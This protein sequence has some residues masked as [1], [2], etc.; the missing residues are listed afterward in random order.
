MQKQTIA[1]YTPAWLQKPS[2]G[3][4]VFTP[5]PA[6]PTSSFLSQSNGTDSASKRAAKPGP[7]RTIARRGTEVFIA[8]GK[9]I[10]WADLVYLK[11]GWEYKEAKK[12]ASRRGG[13]DRGFRESS[14]YEAD[15]AQG[16]RVSSLGSLFTGGSAESIPD[17][18]NPGSGRYQ[19]TSHFPQWKLSRH[20]DYTYGP[21]CD[22]T[23]TRPPYCCRY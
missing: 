22:P 16:Y 21:Y 13:D 3:H 9:E 20:P 18:K 6:K 19:T 8:V 11:Q 1:E 10:R 7:R 17:H 12:A 5:I 15:H 23:G 14:Q 4:G 2:P